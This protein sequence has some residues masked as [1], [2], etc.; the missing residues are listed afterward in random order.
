M[1]PR[2]AAQSA[3]CLA[4]PQAQGHLLP[5]CSARSPRAR[6][7]AVTGPPAGTR[8]VLIGLALSVN[9]LNRKHGPQM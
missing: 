6:P 5:T 4:E 7:P 8:L 9:A 2:D 3:A 1:N